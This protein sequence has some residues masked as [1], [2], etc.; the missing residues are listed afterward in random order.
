MRPRFFCVLSRCATSRRCLPGDKGLL[1]R[2]YTKGDHMTAVRTAGSGAGRPLVS[3]K[4]L[5]LA[6]ASATAVLVAGALALPQ[7]A[8][9]QAAPQTAQ[10]NQTSQAPA[11]EEIVVTGSL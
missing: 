4:R 11:V 10:A 2:G 1:G 9:A 7:A 8:F 5:Y 3:K 6:T